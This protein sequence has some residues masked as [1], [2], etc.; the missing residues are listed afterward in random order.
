MEGTRQAT[1]SGRRAPAPLRQPL[2][3]HKASEQ[4]PRTGRL[5]KQ[6]RRFPLCRSGAG[7]K[8][9]GAGRRTSRGHPRRP[10]DCG[11]ER[12]RALGENAL[13][14][15][16]RRKAAC[17]LGAALDPLLPPCAGS[18]KRGTSKPPTHK[19]RGGAGVPRYLLLAARSSPTA[20]VPEPAL[21]RARRRALGTGCPPP[22]QE[23]ETQLSPV[24]TWRLLKEPLGLA[25][26][27]RQPQARSPRMRRASWM[28]LG[29]MVTRLA[30][31]AQRLVSSKSP[32]R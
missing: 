30:W 5:T 7:T 29:M 11:E 18:F 1:K 31:M 22:L 24:A 16:S 26:A 21:P 8:R 4:R 20:Y 9:D 27:G 3:C 15:P 12:L 17:S 2:P 25:V 13:P 32:T 10:G 28:S 14:Y 19:R 23:T 6:R